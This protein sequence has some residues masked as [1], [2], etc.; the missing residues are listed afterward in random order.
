MRIH[1][2]FFVGLGLT[3]NDLVSTETIGSLKEFLRVYGSRNRFG[4]DMEN[5]RL[6][7][8]GKNIE[9]DNLKLDECGFESWNKVYV[10]LPNKRGFCRVGDRV[11]L[12]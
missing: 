11:R 1:F 5:I 9:D 10:I 7:F 6:V 8:R 4:F 12:V 2:I 3:L